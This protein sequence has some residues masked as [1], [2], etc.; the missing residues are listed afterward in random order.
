MT[1]FSVWECDFEDLAVNPSSSKGG[2]QQ[3]LQ[4]VFVPVLKNTQRRGKI[5]PGTLS[6]SFPLILAKKIGTYHLSQG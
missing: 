6:S 2:L 4:T 1:K 5:T 3:P